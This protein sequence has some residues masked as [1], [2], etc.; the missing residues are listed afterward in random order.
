[1]YWKIRALLK[2]IGK[3]I[4]LMKPVV[5]VL[6]QIECSIASAWSRSAHSRLMAVQWALPPQPENFDH[7]IDLFYWWLKTRNPQWVERGVY[8]ALCLKGGKVLE[9][10]CG[11]GFNARNFYSLNSESVIGCDFDP[12]IL[13][14]ARRKNRAPNVSLVEADIRTDMPDGI[15]DNIVWDAAIEHFTPKEIDAIMKNIKR[16]LRPDGIVSGHTVVE[17]GE[18]QKH[19]SHH[20]YEFK[21]KEDLRR[22]FTPHFKNVL[23]FETVYPGR[24]NLYFWASNGIIPFSP[25]WSS[26][27]NT[28]ATEPAD[29]GNSLQHA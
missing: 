5:E 27:C 2:Q 13:K 29:T 23:V 16:R 6:S 20:E 15:F 4:G 22:F 24:R 12:I 8:S 11:D 26:G 3:A 14:T 18:G 9:L 7:H 28:W 1:M 25:Q 21:D 19:L 10:C 17:K